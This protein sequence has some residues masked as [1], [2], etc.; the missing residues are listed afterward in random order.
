MAK[1]FNKK[2]CKKVGAI[3]EKHRESKEEEETKTKQKRRTFT[4]S[5]TLLC[6]QK[7][8]FFN[9]ILQNN[10]HIEA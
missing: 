1:F 9:A 10:T 5:V 4:S 6:Y 2:N 3:I 8:T 7:S